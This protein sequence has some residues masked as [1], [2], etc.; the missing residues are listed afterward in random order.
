MR[1]HSPRS[2][3]ERT[4]ISSFDSPTQTLCEL[5]VETFLYYLN[6]SEVDRGS[7]CRF[8]FGIR[9]MENGDLGNFVLSNNLKTT[10]FH[11][12]D[13]WHVIIDVLCRA[14]SSKDYQN[15]P[16]GIPVES[17]WQESFG[18]WVLIIK[19]EARFGAKRLHDIMPCTSQLQHQG[20][21]LRCSDN[22]Q[23][24][25][26]ENFRQGTFFEWFF[27]DFLCSP[28]HRPLSYDECPSWYRSV[29]ACCC[30]LFTALGAGERGNIIFRACSCL[31]KTC[32]SLMEDS[33]SACWQWIRV[34]ENCRGNP[35]GSL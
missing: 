34:D 3:Q 9:G 33:F 35:S 12:L 6:C 24:K 30:L 13:L 5:F 17:R 32:C 4:G 31:K 28:N 16:S 14:Q 21:W 27:N 22:W 23:L 29:R 15:R 1:F 8:A 18:T 20:R 11:F 26:S 25:H 19:K 2:V 10:W 7:W